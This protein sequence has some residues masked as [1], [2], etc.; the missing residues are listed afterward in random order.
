MLKNRPLNPKQ[1]LIQAI[2]YSANHP[3]LYDVLQ[4][5]SADMSILEYYCMDVLITIF[6]CLIIS[7]W[8]LIVAIRKFI[9]YLLYQKKKEKK[10]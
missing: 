4:L 8:I 3:E 2:E 6:F 10:A 1:E 9:S 5:E 7:V